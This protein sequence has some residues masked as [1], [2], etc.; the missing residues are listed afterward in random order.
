MNYWSLYSGVIVLVYTYLVTQ[1]SVVSHHARF[2]PF[3]CGLAVER[4]PRGMLTLA[5]HLLYLIR[6]TAVLGAESD[7]ATIHIDAVRPIWKVSS[8]SSRR[9]K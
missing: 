8:S 1:E 7:I 3:L 9:S 4:E 2:F 5:S 6:K